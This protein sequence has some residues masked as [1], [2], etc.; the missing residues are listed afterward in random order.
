M[1]TEKLLS[2]VF[3]TWEG[4]FYPPNILSCLFHSSYSDSLFWFFCI[5]A[6]TGSFPYNIMPLSTFLLNLQTPD[7]S[8]KITTSGKN[9]LSLWLRQVLYFKSL[10]ATPLYAR[11]CGN[12]PFHSHFFVKCMSSPV[13]W[14]FQNATPG[15]SHPISTW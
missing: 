9:Y 6:F 5:K 4:T 7:F 12:S 11:C 10:Y 15:F 3:K 8:S 14:K 1:R 2:T 13:G